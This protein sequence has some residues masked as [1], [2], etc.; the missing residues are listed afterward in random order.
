MNKIMAYIITCVLSVVTS[1]SSYADSF[2]GSISGV[3]AGEVHNEEEHFYYKYK[4]QYF[5]SGLFHVKAFIYS[6][7]GDD[8]GNFYVTGESIEEG[9]WSCENNTLAT[10]TEYI[11]GEKKI[12]PTSMYRI[13][14]VSSVYM[15]TETVEG[16]FPG[17]IH[18]MYKSE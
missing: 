6:T 3:W 13:L 8:E 16:Y 2:C 15:K 14:E 17:I 10:K 1:L 5:K 9:S 12:R 4:L 11:N 18:E 7:D